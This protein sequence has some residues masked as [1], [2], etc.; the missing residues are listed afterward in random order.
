LPSFSGDI[1]LK[2]VSSLVENITN[3]AQSTFNSSNEIGIDE[4]LRNE[5]S[6]PKSILRAKQYED[7]V[8][9]FIE[10]ST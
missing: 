9:I 4:T 5:P 6:K 2:T 3:I 1:Q 10:C 8:I 7:K